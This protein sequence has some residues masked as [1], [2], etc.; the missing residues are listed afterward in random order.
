VAWISKCT[1]LFILLV[2]VKNEKEF[3]FFS[4]GRSIK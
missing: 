1:T 3:N 2:L 4:A